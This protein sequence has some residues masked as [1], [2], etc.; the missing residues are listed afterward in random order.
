[1][2]KSRCKNDDTESGAASQKLNTP[3]PSNNSA[4]IPT[5]QVNSDVHQESNDNHPTPPLYYV[6]TDFSHIQPELGQSCEAAPRTLPAKL[7]SMLSD[8]GEF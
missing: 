6:Y 1:M 2:N 8:P 3:G 5:Q 4:L 7:N